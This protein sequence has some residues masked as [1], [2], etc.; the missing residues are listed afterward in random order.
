MKAA[1]QM[2]LNEASANL[3]RVLEVDTDGNDDEIYVAVEDL[4]KS[5]ERLRRYGKT[6]LSLT[7]DR[8]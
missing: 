4:Q 6:R 8:L 2:W 7:E 1:A 3:K 5:I